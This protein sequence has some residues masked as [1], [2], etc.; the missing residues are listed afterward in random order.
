[1][2]ADIKDLTDHIHP[3]AW[4][5]DLCQNVSPCR[6]YHLIVYQIF[7]HLLLHGIFYQ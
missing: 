4:T 7:L 2:Y 6:R 5:I 3:L 1:M